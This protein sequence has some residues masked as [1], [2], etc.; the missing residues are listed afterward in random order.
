MTITTKRKPLY[1]FE[2]TDIIE[3]HSCRK[4]YAGDEYSRCIYC[5]A[6]LMYQ[7]LVEKPYSSEQIQELYNTELIHKAIG[8]FNLLPYADTK[9]LEQ[10]MVLFEDLKSAM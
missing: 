5:N 9:T 10:I 2:Y 3:C 8:V 7:F 6:G 1:N 4:L